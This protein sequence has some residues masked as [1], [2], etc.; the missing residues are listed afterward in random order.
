MRKLLLILLCGCAT[1]KMMK[2]FEADGERLRFDLA[3]T[4]VEKGAYV[5]ALPLIQRSAAEHPNEPTIRALHG[6]VLRERSLYPQAERELKAAL[7]LKPDYAAAWAA[8]GMVY[9]LMGRHAEAL[10]AHKRSV[11]I[12]PQDGSYWNNY[13][14]SLYLQGDD[15]QAIDAFNRALALDA[16]LVVAYNNLGFTYARKKDFASARRC[17]ES[18]MGPAGQ[19]NLALALEQYGGPEE[20]LAAKALRADAPREGNP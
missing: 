5:A 3:R 7:A 15:Q 1:Q 19:L 6:V 10:A 11:E 8:L 16:S 14:F 20:R 12:A 2:Q 18:G 9:D 17:F 13:G 4:Y